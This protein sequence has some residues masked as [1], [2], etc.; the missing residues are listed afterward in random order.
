VMTT[1]IDMPDKF[2]GARVCACVMLMEV[3]AEVLGHVTSLPVH[4]C[5][6]DVDGRSG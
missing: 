5:V 3:A 4:A 6:C 2:A 1:E